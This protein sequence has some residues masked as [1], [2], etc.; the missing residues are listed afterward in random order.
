MKRAHE[1]VRPLRDLLLVFSAPLIW[2]AHLVTLYCAETLICTG[3]LTKASHAMTWITVFA[4]AIAL[5]GL[6][7]LAAIILFRRPDFQGRRSS[8]FFATLS[9]LLTPLSA[10]AIV[11]TTL[12]TILLR[13]CE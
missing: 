7:I 8:G 6:A 1:Q 2:F 4:T 11:W 12:P 3:V 10:F 13:T 9:L 5:M